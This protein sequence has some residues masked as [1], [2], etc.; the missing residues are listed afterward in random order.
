MPPR[1]GGGET[2]GAWGKAWGMYRGSS[3][4]RDDIDR[5]DDA[6]EIAKDRQQHV[7]PE[8]RAK[9]DLQENPEGRQK[10]REDDAKNVHN[11]F[12]V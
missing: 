9:P 7:D 4:F 8:L 3:A 5:V 10:D 1:R 11:K 12:P 6:G 2:P